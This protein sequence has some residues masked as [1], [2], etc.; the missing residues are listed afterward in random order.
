MIEL[1][2][3]TAELDQMVGPSYYR[4]LVTGGSVH[5]DFTDHLVDGFFGRRP[6]MPP[7]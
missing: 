5:A 6:S 2:H 7:T 1:S 4:A 3:L